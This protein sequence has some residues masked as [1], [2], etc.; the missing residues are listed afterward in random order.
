[1]TVAIP[2]ATIAL[3]TTATAIATVT[4]AQA[5]TTKAK[6]S[7][8][9]AA[10]AHAFSGE[11]GGPL[12][13]VEWNS[14]YNPNKH[15][16]NDKEAIHYRDIKIM[17]KQSLFQELSRDEKYVYF[18]SWRAYK[19]PS[20]GAL[21]ILKSTSLLLYPRTTSTI[22]TMCGSYYGNYYGGR[23]YGCCGYGGL[24]YGYGGLGY[25]YGGLGCG[26]GGLG[27]GYGGLGCGY[28][29]CY[30]CGYRRLGCGY[31]CGYGYGSRP[32]YGCGYGCGSGYGY[33]Y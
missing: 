26:Y 24:G 15:R 19:K 17:T 33:Y 25:G 1:M 4:T 18:S 6:T 27:C 12:K 23:G 20:V 9:V 8:V 2:I 3:A 5:T 28:G 16:L 31:G 30:G 11:M 29:S 32:L 21:S 13:D 10:V 14:K 7:T 22:N